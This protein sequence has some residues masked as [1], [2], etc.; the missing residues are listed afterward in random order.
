MRWLQVK[1]KLQTLATTSPSSRVAQVA[2]KLAQRLGDT[3][4]E[5]VENLTDEAG[6]PVAGLFDP[7]QHH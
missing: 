3:E 7:K 6:M 4:V 1:D 5:V 2:R